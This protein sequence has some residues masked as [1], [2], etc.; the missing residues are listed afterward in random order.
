MSKFYRQ[1]RQERQEKQKTAT[2][3]GIFAW[4]SWRP[5]R[6]LL[7]FCDF[8]VHLHFSLRRIAKSFFNPAYRK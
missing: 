5:W 8:A 2:F 6:L 7:L 4:R 3:R 1:G